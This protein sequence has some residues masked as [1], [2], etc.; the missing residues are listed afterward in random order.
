M[1]SLHSA[2]E[3]VAHGSVEVAFSPG[4]RKKT[5]A[6]LAVV[7]FLACQPQ[8]QYRVSWCPFRFPLCS[9]KGDLELC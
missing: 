4:A 3:I 8:P 2:R 5:N 6:G 7:F 9:T 1:C